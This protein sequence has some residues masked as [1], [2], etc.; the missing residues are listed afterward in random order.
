VNEA[1]VV[2]RQPKTIKILLHLTTLEGLDLEAAAVPLSERVRRVCAE[3]AVP[4]HEEGLGE[5][6]AAAAALVV[7]VV[8]GGVVAER[9]VETP[10]WSSTPL[11]VA[12]TKKA[13]ATRGDMPEAR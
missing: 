6:A 7:H 12:K 8:V 11:T 1:D 5:V 9:G 4:D 3:Q 10:Q 2:R 13:A